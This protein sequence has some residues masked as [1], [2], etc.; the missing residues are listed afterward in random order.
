MKAIY[1]TQ[2]NKII[3]AMDETLNALESHRADI[4]T[5]RDEMQEDFD[6]HSEKW[7]ESEAAES[8]QE[9]IDNIETVL[10]AAE[11]AQSECQDAFNDLENN[12]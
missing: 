4:E 3:S 2:I 7:Q 12:F 10:S 1:K 5:L 8:A 11:N 9:E 6:N